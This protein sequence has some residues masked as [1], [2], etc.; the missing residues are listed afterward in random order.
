MH[1]YTASNSDEEVTV[2][3][4]YLKELI[5]KSRRPPSFCE[6][7]CT[8]G[9]YPAGT[10]LTA[11][12]F[13]K[14]CPSASYPGSPYPNPTTPFA[15]MSSLRLEKPP[16]SA[17]T[18]SLRSST[19]LPSG[20]PNPQDLINLQSYGI[21]SSVMLSAFS[22]VQPSCTSLQT[23]FS[24]PCPTSLTPIVSPLP[25]P[26]IVSPSSSN[27]ISTAKQPINLRKY[28]KL[29][30][31]DFNLVQELI[32]ANEPLK[33]PLDLHFNGELTLM[34]VVK[35][36]EAALK[37]IVCMARDLAAFQQLDI[38]DKKNIMKGSCSELL[39]L[40]GVMAF[41]PN[42]NTW[43]HNFTTV[44]SFYGKVGELRQRR[45]I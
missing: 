4:A 3:K 34:D 23:A 20:P 25:C 6:C 13:E 24:P 19:D 39:I 31:E 16:P 12:N 29:S 28:A 43:N 38:E 37:R 14:E 35:I 32:N 15:Q 21:G 17:V 42:K 40:R 7:T 22:T 11:L 33:A 18:P 36:S 30:A 5:R 8:C 10:R 41:D 27:V 9:F 44:S 2:P 45:T 26:D 1:R